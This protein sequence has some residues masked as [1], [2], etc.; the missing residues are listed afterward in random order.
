MIIND[1]DILVAILEGD[2]AAFHLFFNAWHERVYHYF[3]KK[4]NQE[5]DAKDLTQ[6]TFIKFWQYRHLLTTHHSAETQLIQKAR[7]IYIDWLRKCAHQ[8]KLLE[9]YPGQPLIKTDNSEVHTPNLEQ[10]LERLPKMR[11][12][13]IELSHL[14]GYKYKE[15]AAQL[16]IS[17]KT[18]DNHVQQALKQLR[19]YLTI[20]LLLF[21]FLIH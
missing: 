7:L 10:A 19:K 20:I 14:Q 17:V 18:V 9:Q 6:Q 1:Q 11:R 13:V 16:N 15:V 4:L 5:Q 12:K 21:S 2:H 8:Q 3:L